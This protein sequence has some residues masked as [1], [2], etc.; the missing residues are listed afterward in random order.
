MVDNKHAKT[1]KHCLQLAGGSGT[2]VTL[3]IND[4]IDT[5]GDLT[6]WAERWTKRLPFSFRIE[7]KRGQG[8]HEIYNG[9]K[10]VRVGRAFLNHI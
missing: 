5:T 4:Q 10:Q 2:S 9:D 7:A 6:F 1:G 3:N 8:W